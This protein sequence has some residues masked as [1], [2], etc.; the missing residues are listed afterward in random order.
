MSSKAVDIQEIVRRDHLDSLNIEPRKAK[1]KRKSFLWLMLKGGL[2]LAALYG[3]G[4]ATEKGLEWGKSEATRLH[5]L[6]MSRLR[7]VEVVKEYVDPLDHATPE[8]IEIV[9]K[10]M[11]INP[12]I[13]DAIIQKESSY[14]NS[15][16][17]TEEKLCDRLQVQDDNGVM[18]CSSHGLMQ[19][20]GIEARR[21]CKIEWSQLYDR[22]TNIKCGLTILKNN[23][24]QTKEKQPGRRLR[25]ALR[26]Y[27]GSGPKAEA[28][29]DSV[30]SLIA[31]RLLTDLSK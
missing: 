24:V 10:E 9:S 15:S 26:I 4:A 19:I 29:A 6:V 18:L 5:E 20:L 23:L 2:L 30:M 11:G 16:I 12:V 13:T 31:D 21:Q 28:Y 7:T 27:N 17:R 3:T 1:R 14:Q 25:E 22:R 8:L